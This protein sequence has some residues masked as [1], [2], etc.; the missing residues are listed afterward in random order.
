MRMGTEDHP[1]NNKEEICFEFANMD[2]RRSAG[3]R[4]NCRSCV[5]LFVCFGNSLCTH[6]NYWPGES[7]FFRVG[8]G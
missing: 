8:M 3:G 7:F 2:N 5:R 6:E 4:G 1:K